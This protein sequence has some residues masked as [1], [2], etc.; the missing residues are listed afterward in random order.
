MTPLQW[1]KELQQPIENAYGWS[2]K[3]SQNRKIFEVQFERRLFS[4]VANTNRKQDD[5]TYMKACHM[6]RDTYDGTEQLYKTNCVFPHYNL[7]KCIKFRFIYDTHKHIYMMNYIYVYS[8][9]SYHS[10][11]MKYVYFILRWKVKSFCSSPL[12]HGFYRNHGH[13]CPLCEKG[14]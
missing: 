5:K 4:N 2:Y 10:H 1:N 14:R 8:Y 11:T 7:N 12:L 3:G 13:R 9:I 6:S